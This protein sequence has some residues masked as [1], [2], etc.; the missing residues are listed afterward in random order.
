MEE[1]EPGIPIST[2]EIKVPDTPPI[3][4]AKSTIKE[5]CVDSPKVTGSSNEIPRVAD[6]PG[7]AP[8]IIPT[9][10]TPV[11]RRRFSG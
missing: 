11:I 7:I 3:H 1:L 2:A 5:V 8:K 6:S 9:T 4:M 10:E